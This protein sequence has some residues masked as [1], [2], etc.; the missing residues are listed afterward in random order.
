M[1]HHTCDFMLIVKTLD[2][3][4]LYNVG[5]C[6]NV[7]Q[8]FQSFTTPRLKFRRADMIEICLFARVV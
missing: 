7:S 3:Y 8:T 4:Q 1:L 2:I 6:D 5:G